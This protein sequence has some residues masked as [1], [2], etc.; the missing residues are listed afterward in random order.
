MK[1][2]LESSRLPPTKDCAILHV[3][4][5]NYRCH[6]WKCAQQPILNLPSPIGNGWIKPNAGKLV[7]ELM[8]NLPAPENLI[9]LTVCRCAKGCM[10]NTC[11]CRKANLTCIESC[12]CG[13]LCANQLEED[14]DIEDTEE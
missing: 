11:K 14:S 3:H 4:R 9:E 12:S 5:A 1:K 2:G 13:E 8:K 6:I 7:P 10:N